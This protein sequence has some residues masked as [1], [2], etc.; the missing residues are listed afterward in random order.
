MIIIVNFQKAQIINCLKAA[1]AFN[2]EF[3][4]GAHK[5]NFP[6]HI[7][8]VIDSYLELVV[9]LIWL[10]LITLSSFI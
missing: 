3:W 10:S 8:Y 6:F 2:S 7:K 9:G 4:N 1:T 5:N